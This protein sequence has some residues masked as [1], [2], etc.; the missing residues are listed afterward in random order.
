M[1]SPANERG[2]DRI[3]T[4][5][6]VILVWTSHLPPSDPGAYV[7]EI[8]K[9]KYGT[10]PPKVRDW[11]VAAVLGFS[12]HPTIDDAKEIY[13]KILEQGKLRDY[14][15]P[16]DEFAGTA[17]DGSPVAALFFW[18]KTRAAEGKKRWWVLGR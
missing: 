13:A 1:T 12:M 3:P 8:V 5:V 2:R 7:Q 11:Q 14:G 15:T 18:E 9:A 10:R 6:K 17:A 4:S 16:S